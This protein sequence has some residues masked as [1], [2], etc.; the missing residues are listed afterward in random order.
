MH[1]IAVCVVRG[2]VVRGSQCNV[3][4]QGEA[5][6]VSFVMESDMGAFTPIGLKFSGQRSTNALSIH[7]ST[8]LN[9][10]LPG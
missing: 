3:L 9:V 10:F 5:G 4:L 1:Y 7:S 2:D 6:N 8:L